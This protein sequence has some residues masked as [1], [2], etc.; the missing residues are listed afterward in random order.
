MRVIAIVVALIV[1]LTSFACGGSAPA[2]DT[3]ADHRYLGDGVR[4]YFIHQDSARPRCHSPSRMTHDWPLGSR[5]WIDAIRV[6]YCRSLG[7]NGNFGYTTLVQPR[8]NGV[9]LR[10]S[11]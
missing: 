5:G 10:P 11:C 9:F 1:A 2:T 8:R 4:K 7:Q 3:D 6:A